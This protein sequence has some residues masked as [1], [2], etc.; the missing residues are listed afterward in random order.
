MD[1]HPAVRRRPR[2]PAPVVIDAPPRQTF[3]LPTVL[4]ITEDA[5]FLAPAFSAETLLW[6]WRAADGA[7]DDVFTGDPTDPETY[8]FVREIHDLSAL[9]ALPDQEQATRVA[10]AIQLVNP[11]AAVLVVGERELGAAA[12][13][14]AR[15]VDWRRALRGEL[16]DELRQLESCK[17]V[18]ALRAFAED[19]AIVPILI[20][21]DPD[22]DALA[23]AMAIRV[24]LRREPNQAPILTLDEITRPENRRMAELLDIQVTQVTK[25]ELLAFDRIICA[26]MQPRDFKGLECPRLAVIDHHPPESGYDA[27][28]LDIRP[29]YG[30]TATLLTEYIRVIDERWLGDRLATALLYA[31]KTDTDNL[32]RGVSPADVVAYNFLLER[33]DA[34]LLRRIER[35]A[36]AE[37]TA[38]AY[39]RGIADMRMKNDL[40]VAF[41]GNMS[42]DDSHI[43]ADVADFLLAMDEA[44]WAAAAAIVEQRLV[45][46]LRHLGNHRGA[47]ALARALADHGAGSGG[48]HATMARAVLK[49]EKEWGT[50]ADAPLEEA[51][52]L[53]LDRL[54]T[55][56]ER[57]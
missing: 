7:E 6:R 9:V 16:E 35:P 28:Y 40:A 38:R 23:S 52:D 33:A 31:I 36:Y 20:H 21:Q 57:L 32:T 5:D 25:A 10:A 54:A 56:L 46:N 19:A 50:L 17:R 48:G 44:T 27:E 14:L 47:G 55:Y 49:L 13:P 29:H 18:Q 42:V 41:L 8:E 4:L 12:G 45:V 34:L 1:Q 11:E 53:L 30:A 51:R 15:L 3:A 22:P 26:D 37:R 2:T 39:G 24:L 43:L